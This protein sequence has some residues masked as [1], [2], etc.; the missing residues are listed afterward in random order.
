[1][2]KQRAPAPGRDAE[3]LY[4]A[5]LALAAQAIPIVAPP[6]G[7]PLPS[8]PA[9]PGVPA[10]LNDEHDILTT[11]R[12]QVLGHHSDGG[13]DVY[14]QERRQVHRIPDVSRLQLPTLLQ[15]CG[16]AA[17]DHVH[18]N[19]EPVPGRST[20][21]Q[22]RNAISLFAGQVSLT[23]CWP[24]GQGI[25]RADGRICLV[26]AGRAATFAGGRLTNL[27]VP[28]CGSQVLD[29]SSSQ[30]WTDFVAL[31]GLL[32]LARDP[33]WCR[34]VLQQTIDL[35]AKWY[36]K[37][38][39]DA[40]VAACLACA[41]WV[42]T[43]WPWRPEINVTGTSGSGKTM[44]MEEVLSRLYGRLAA[45]STKSTE[46]GLR[47]QI[48]NRSVA[49]LVDEFEGG[50]ERQRVLDLFRS[51]GRGSEIM[52]GT[53]DQR[54][55]R[56]LLR[57]M[58]WFGNIESGLNDDTDKN[59]FILLNLQRPPKKKNSRI[60]LPDEAQLQ[61]LGQRLL[62]VAL[63]VFDRAVALWLAAKVTQVEDIHQRIIESFAVPAAVYGAC[64]GLDEVGT[65]GKL[66]EFLADKRLVRDNQANEQELL[67]TILE[68]HF[69]VAPGRRASVAEALACET[70]YAE[71]RPALER[72]GVALCSATRGPRRYVSG[73][74]SRLFL[75]PSAVKRYLLKSTDWS[76]K[77][78]GQ[79][80]ERLPGAEHVQRHIAGKK[81]WGWLLPA[82]ELTA[83]DEV[84]SNAARLKQLND[85]LDDLESPDGP[86]SQEDKPPP[87]VG[88]A[89]EPD[90]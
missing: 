15:I 80:L 60:I 78:I 20:L 89:W 37:H 33:L 68:S 35:F 34:D 11:I 44:F 88:D 83:P 8:A 69:D 18:A 87:Q 90:V 30:E 70:T 32:D 50:H 63:T 79:L 76:L 7:S 29:F 47:Q 46:A 43:L 71:V 84:P 59:R 54:G 38:S 58:P 48:R 6:P 55:R 52:R 25:W 77:D 81:V 49:V 39:V 12:L 51:T 72:Y 66:R 21:E 22:V 61:A 40:Q 56:Y 23:D 14:S 45:F 24:V 27:D 74:D 1:M 86:S 31:Q 26:N 73:P 19:R 64:F 82:E 4:D 28:R 57:H 3:G 17:R 9:I 65:V 67:A 36:W 42:Q 16:L 13:V 5:L 62:A 75:N 41:T 10:G 85:S 53:S 2:S